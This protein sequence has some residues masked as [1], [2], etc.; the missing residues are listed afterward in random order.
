[1]LHPPTEI[2]NRCY[3]SGKTLQQCTMM[4]LGANG[5]N[6]TLKLIARWMTT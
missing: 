2:L 4:L 1:M 6:F 3:L 5:S